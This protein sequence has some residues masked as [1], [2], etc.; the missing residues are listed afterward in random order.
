MW[1]FSKYSAFQI[2]AGWISGTLKMK[3]YSYYST[4]KMRLQQAF[5]LC[6]CFPLSKLKAIMQWSQLNMEALQDIIS[7]ISYHE[8]FYLRNSGMGGIKTIR[9]VSPCPSLTMVHST[10]AAKVHLTPL[11]T[12]P[13]I[14]LSLITETLWLLCVTPLT[15]IPFWLLSLKL[16]G[17][18]PNLALGWA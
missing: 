3:Q 16:E 17:T 15:G 1:Y 7:P 18:R 13:R 6:Y 12:K 9:L 4:Q 5:V 14:S 11:A 8:Y 10:E 2:L